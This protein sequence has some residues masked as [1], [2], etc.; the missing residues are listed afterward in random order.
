MRSD[1]VR[2]KFRLENWPV[3]MFRKSPFEL[4]ILVVRN[5]MIVY[6]CLS[7]ITLE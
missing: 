6:L 3:E 4:I 2:R 7:E 5:E 1:N